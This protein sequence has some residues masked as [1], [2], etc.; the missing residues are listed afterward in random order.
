ML[1]ALGGERGP[2]A[3]AVYVIMGAVG[4]PV[5]SGFKGGASALLGNTG[6]YIIGFIFMGL[7]QVI[8]NLIIIFVKTLKMIKSQKSII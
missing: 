4:V 1:L 7:I 6:G 5:F 3:A 8:K 2:I